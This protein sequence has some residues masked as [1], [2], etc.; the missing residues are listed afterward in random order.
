[1]NTTCLI[2]GV[3]LQEKLSGECK[4]GDLFL[5]GKAFVVNAHPQILPA[6]Q[7]HEDSKIVQYNAV[8]DHFERRNVYVFPSSCLTF[9]DA[10]RDYVL[11]GAEVFL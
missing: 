9:N 10:A 3:I 6:E 2:T 11:K 5:C 1:M 7:V 4:A 8:G